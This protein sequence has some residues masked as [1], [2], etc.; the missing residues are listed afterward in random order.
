MK[1]YI[2]FLFGPVKYFKSRIDPQ[3]AIEIAKKNLKDRIE[4]R[5]ENFLNLI[6][7]G[8]FGIVIRVLLIFSYGK[9]TNK[10]DYSFVTNKLVLY[11]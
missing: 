10:F 1:K 8:I 3:Q 11:L 7:K 2:R 4:H 6:K 9:Y 5:E